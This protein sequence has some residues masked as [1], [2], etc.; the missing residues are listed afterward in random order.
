MNVWDVRMLSGARI[1][2]LFRELDE[3]LRHDGVHD[4]A[5]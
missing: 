2:E 4:P 1:L 5:G 3:E